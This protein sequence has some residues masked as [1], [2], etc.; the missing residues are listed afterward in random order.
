MK[1]KLLFSIFTIAC[2]FFA[3]CDKKENDPKDKKE[4]GDTTK[5]IVNV[6]K[7]PKKIDVKFN[8]YDY[9]PFYSIKFEYDSKGRLI[10][11]FDYYKE[12]VTNT[13]YIYSEDKVIESKE[14]MGNSSSSII[15]KYFYDK[16]GKVER[17]ESNE[18]DYKYKILYYYE[19]NNSLI[20]RADSKYNNKESVFSDYYFYDSK[21]NLIKENTSSYSTKYEYEYDDKINPFKHL[22]IMPKTYISIELWGFNTFVNNI[23]KEIRNGNSHTYTYEYD[24]DGYPTQRIDKD[25]K[26][27]VWRTITYEY[28]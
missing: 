21:G 10:K 15:R 11:L 9:F 24:K 23:I 3:A 18:Y 14:W 4:G 22:H 2:I 26:G 20:T 17:I 28:Q 8:N 1:H 16:S 27:E 7:K 5:P 13:E 25:E 19:N 6:I 12:Y